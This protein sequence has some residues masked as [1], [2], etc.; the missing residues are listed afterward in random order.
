[1]AITGG[2]IAGLSSLSVAG[3]GDVSGDYKVDGVKVVSNRRTG[4]TAPTGPSSRATFD[5]SSI[6]APQIAQR[7]K[8]LIDD[9]TAHGLIGS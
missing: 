3:D 1:T 2:T 6:S 5:S 8:A 4:W 7:L 9:L